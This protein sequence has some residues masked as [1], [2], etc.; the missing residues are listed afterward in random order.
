MTI[1]IEI[2]P[3]LESQI[4]QAAA[5]AG[6]PLAAYV[7]ESVTERLHPTQHRQS[8]VKHL[9]KIEANLIQKINQSLSQIEWLR[10][11]ELIAKRQAETLTPDEQVQLIALSDQIE[12]ANV[13]R[14]EYVAELAQVRKT[15]IPAVMKELGLRPVAYA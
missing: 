13:K 2:A 6:I 12:E 1:V 15:T 10:Y 4:R 5:N 8:G 11:R 3:E 14:I 9:P 7:V